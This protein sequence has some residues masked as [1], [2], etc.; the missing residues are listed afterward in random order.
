VYRLALV[1]GAL[2]AHLAVLI[3]LQTLL[4]QPAAGKA[5]SVAADRTAA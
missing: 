5:G 1:I 2:L 4:R 3:G